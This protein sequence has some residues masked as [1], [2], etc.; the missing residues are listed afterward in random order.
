MA[1]DSRQLE[2]SARR[3]Y[4]RWA[5]ITCTSQRT[6]QRQPRWVPAMVALWS[7]RWMQRVC[8]M[9]V[10]PSTAQPMRCGL[11]RVPPEYLVDRITETLSDTEDTE[12]TEGT[13]G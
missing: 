10:S 4:V 11:D 6:W 12:G 1:P 5:A 2:Q 9:T 3:V 7:S 8:T 13:E